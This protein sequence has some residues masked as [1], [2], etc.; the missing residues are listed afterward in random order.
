MSEERLSGLSALLDHEG[1]HTDL[2]QTLEA[3]SADRGMRHAAVRYRMIG[4][5]LRGDAVRR[6][7]VQ[8]AERIRQSIDE[9]PHV[10]SPAPSNPAGK[11]PGP[12][13]RIA[14]GL[15][16]AAS[17][18]TVAIAVFP[19]IEGPPPESEATVAL[20]PGLPRQMPAQSVTATSPAPLAKPVTASGA[21]QTI[22]WDRYLLDHDEF[23][24]RGLARGIRP[25]AT[26][27]AIDGR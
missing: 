19:R 16:I 27:V 15:A 26:L 17:V 1:D 22:S 9:E 18:A 11:R 13:L 6:D 25:H 7:A 20:A 23:A 21:Q 14:A 24:T 12:V 4:D 3:L 10:L 5:A 8:L 2:E